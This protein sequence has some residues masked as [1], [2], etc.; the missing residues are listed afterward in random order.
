[1]IEY[2]RAVVDK[3]DLSQEQAREALKTIMN[4]SSTL[5][6]TASFITALRMKGE[7][8]EEITGFARAMRDASEKIFVKSGFSIDTC[9]TGGDGTHTFNISTASAIITSACGITVS[10]HGNRS[11]SSKSG[12]ADVLEALGIKINLSPNEVEDCVNKIGIGFL[13]APIFHKSMKHAAI[14]RSEIGIRTVFSIL[15]P[16]T[17]PANADSQ[18]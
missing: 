5:A 15:G 16:L 1:M 11:V 17:N 9:G 8:I 4:G 7:T 18:L 6:Q 3:K 14:P 12:S 2:I 10:K 13:F